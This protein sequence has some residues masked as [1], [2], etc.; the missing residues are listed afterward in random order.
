MKSLRWDILP[1]KIQTEHLLN[2]SWKS[3]HWS[4][5]AHFYME[6]PIMTFYTI[7]FYVATAIIR[8]WLAGSIYIN[9]HVL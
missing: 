7:P 8:L 1:T 5:L 4:Q 6:G 3:Y 9:I 2:T